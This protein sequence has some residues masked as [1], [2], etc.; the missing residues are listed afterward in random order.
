MFKMDTFWARCMS[1][2]LLLLLPCGRW[3][4][5]RRGSARPD[6]AAGPGERRWESSGRRRPAATAALSP[7]ANV[8]QL[9][10][11]WRDARRPPRH[12]LHQRRDA[13]GQMRTPTPHCEACQSSALWTRALRPD[14][15]WACHGPLHRRTF[16]PPWGCCWERLEPFQDQGSEKH[17][18]RT[19]KPPM[20]VLV[21]HQIS[22]V[23]CWLL[24]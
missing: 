16:P 17:G 19:S 11:T 24:D 10:R 18:N 8:S 21:L 23:F 14:P 3:Q 12:R 2:P 9:Q 15:P 5:I 7:A 20:V 22:S 1:A 13:D 4:P 6:V